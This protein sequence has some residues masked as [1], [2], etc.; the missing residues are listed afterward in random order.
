MAA[1]IAGL[2]DPPVTVPVKLATLLEITI[3]L[4][5]SFSEDITESLEHSPDQ[6]SKNRHAFFLDILKSVRSVLSPLMSEAHAATKKPN[7]M[8]MND[9]FNIFERLELEEPS[10]AFEQAP[11]APSA[12]APIYNA[13][14]PNDIEEDFFVFHLL[15]HD[16]SRL[17]AEVSKAWAGYQQGGYDLI[18][19]S[20]TTNTAVDLARSMVEDSK[21]IFTRRGGAIRML[22]MWYATA[23]IAEGTKESHKQRPADD[24]N[25]AMFKTADAM[26]WPAYTLLDAFS[27]MHKVNP[28]PEMKRGFYGTY[29]PASDRNTKS[30]RDKFKEDKILLLEM[31]P[32]FYFYCHATKSNPPPVEDEFTRLLRTMFQTKEVHLPIVFASTL[33]LDIHHTLRA[34]VDYGFKRLTDATHFIVG[35]IKAEIVFHKDIKMETWPKQNDDAMQHFVETIEFWVHQDQQREIAPRLTRLHIP[36]PFHLYRKHP[37]SCGV[38]R[39]WALMQFHEFGIAFANAWGSVMSCAHL[40]NAVN[41]GKTQDLL[42]KDFDIVIGLQEPKTFF[43]GE[44]PTTPDECL[45]RFALAM[46]ASAANLAKSTRTK[47]GLIHSKKG[48]KGLKELGAIMQAF[49]SRICDANGPKDIRAED[50]QKVLE[51]SSWQYELDDGDNAQQIF[52]DIGESPK[53]APAS[54]LSTSKCVGLIRD[55]LHGE[56]LEIAFDYFRLHR[57]CWRLLRMVKDHVRDDLTRIYGPDYMQKESE[58]PFIV[59]YVLMTASRSQELGG[60]LMAK[61]PGVQVTSKVQEGARYVVEGLIASGAGGLIVERILPHAL[62]LHVDFEVEEDSD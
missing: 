6:D 59:G 52:K 46:G 45:T 40:Y 53:K 26:F 16:L 14:R 2:T 9:L 19:A 23:C 1:F 60:L 22:Q 38:W 30:D 5:Q 61:L 56:V 55:L 37:W 54:Q 18:A 28:H 51:S 33:F 25:F 44:A 34:E 7:T 11:D 27:R 29:N 42:W 3:S 58:L 57:Q 21:S 47:R 13:E 62:D 32:E 12:S 35:D 20:I 49:R 48:P 31:L 41:G 24:M 10:T 17:R 36:E 39:Y 4:R 15:L 8:N 43:V 50:V